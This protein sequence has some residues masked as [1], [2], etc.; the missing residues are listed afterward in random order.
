LKRT[1]KPSAKDSLRVLGEEGGKVFIECNLSF[2]SSSL[3]SMRESRNS[4]C[5]AQASNTV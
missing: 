4:L 5:I 3:V 2:G 1:V